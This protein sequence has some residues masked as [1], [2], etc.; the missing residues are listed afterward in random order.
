MTSNVSEAL[1]ALI[2]AASKGCWTSE[3]LGQDKHYVSIHKFSSLA[4]LQEYDRA[5]SAALG[6]QPEAPTGEWVLVPRE[7]TDEMM[8]AMHETIRIL[9]RPAEK[10]ADIQND[11]EVYRSML[12]AAPNAPA[13]EDDECGDCAYNPGLCDTHD[14]APATAGEGEAVAWRQQLPGGAWSAWAPTGGYA[15][16][17]EQARE[18]GARVEFAYAAP[19]SAAAGVD[20]AMVERAYQAFIRGPFAD[21]GDGRER[22]RA[23]LT[24][25]LQEPE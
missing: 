18:E 17:M 7:P 9:C 14:A 10:T 1:R 16:H 21:C 3:S 13:S 22:W 11:S 5:L 24:A 12:A 19:P 4:D 8:T 6:T 20:E 2:A 15:W 23:A 25:A